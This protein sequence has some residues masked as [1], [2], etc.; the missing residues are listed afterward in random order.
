[1]SDVEKRAR[2]ELL[3]LALASL[4]LRGGERVRLLED[5]SPASGGAGLDRLAIA[6]MAEGEES[7]GLPPWVSL[8]RH[9]KVVLVSDFLSPLEDI[10]AV[11]SR[12]AGIPVT[13]YLLQ[14]LDPAETL[15]PYDGR[16]RFRG[17]EREPEALIPRVENVREAYARRLQA[18]QAGL[19]A[20]C[21]AT[22]FGFGFHRTDHSPETALLTLYMGLG[23]R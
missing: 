6:L 18:Q 14:V 19:E 1:M 13:G 20:I 11:V 21:R 5:P 4:L 7:A 16:V 3:I 22:G 9:A 15:L 10:Q 12:L 2:S 23:G 8:P 17:L